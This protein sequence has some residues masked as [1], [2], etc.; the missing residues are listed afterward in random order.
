[1][2]LYNKALYNQALPGTGVVTSAP[3]VTMK[4]AAPANSTTYE[5][6]AL[7]DNVPPPVFWTVKARSAVVP[8]GIDPKSWLAG[9][10]AMAGGLKADPETGRLAPPPP[11]NETL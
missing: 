11:V 3:I 1:M 4:G 2:P 10:T 8:T 5:T 7:P 6:A 9:V